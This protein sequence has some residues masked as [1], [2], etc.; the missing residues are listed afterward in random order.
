[1]NNE[2]KKDAALKKPTLNK[3]YLKIGS[4]SITMTA[5]VIAVVIIVNMFVAEIPSLYTKFDVSKTKL[6]SV[7]DQ[8]E[9]MVEGL[10]SDVK[11]YVVAQR[12]YEDPVITALLERYTSLSSHVKVGTVDPVANPAALERYTDET[13]NE[14]SVIVESDKRFYIIDYYDIYRTE[15]SEEDYYYYMY[16]G[17]MPNG[18]KFFDG[19]LRFTTAIDYVTRDDLPTMYTLTGHGE[20]VLDDT[21]VDYITSDNIAVIEL[22]LLSSNTVP[23]DCTSILINVPTTDISAEEKD[24]L[25]TYLNDGGS[26]ILVTGGTTYSSK[27]MPNLAAVTEHM[28]LSAEDGLVIETDQNYYTGYGFNL[29]PVL[30]STTEEPLSLMSSSNLYVLASA[31]HGIV[32]DGTHSVTSLLS[33]S[34]SA[35]VKKDLYSDTLDKTDEDPSG[36]FYIGAVSTGNA[37]GKR[38]DASRLVWYSAPTASAYSAEG[39]LPGGNYEMFLA[40]IN[41]LNENE[42]S[43]S[44]AS[45]SIQTEGLTITDA[46]ASVWSVIVVFII[47]ITAFVLGFVVWFKRRKK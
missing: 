27:L 9:A 25:I 3:K 10:T 37:S 23:A 5:V 46:E 41:W 28:G 12:G 20:S 33:T 2:K 4:F 32:S 36:K 26:I 29:L 14:N 35:Y 22:S 42:S 31:A 1:M 47:P 11:F 19:E 40:T 21:Y 34:D 39:G 44:I 8:T 17:Q 16:Y 7:G 15:Y 6:Y 13:L 43:I 45:K 24:R 30:G 18:K 38:S